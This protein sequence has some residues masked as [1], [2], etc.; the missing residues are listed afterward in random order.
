MTLRSPC[1]S[2][3]YFLSNKTAL[4]LRHLLGVMRFRRIRPSDNWQGCPLNVPICHQFVIISTHF[5]CGYVYVIYNL[6]SFSF[7]K[8]LVF[9][10]LGQFVICMKRLNGTNLDRA[11]QESGFLVEIEKSLK[12]RWVS[13][14]S[15]DS[16]TNKSYQNAKHRHGMAMWASRGV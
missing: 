11:G 7:C 13:F 16:T 9:A 1:R 8:T 6:T 12:I 4:N 10:S 5:Q 3:E 2:L 15:Q 14:L